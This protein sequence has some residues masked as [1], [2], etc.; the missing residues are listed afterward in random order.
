MPAVDFNID[1]SEV[2]VQYQPSADGAPTCFKY[3]DRPCA[4]GANG[5]QFAK[6]ADGTRD[7]TRVV[8]CGAACDKVRN[9]QAAK[10]DVI[11]GCTTIH[12]D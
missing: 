11:L 12:V 4:A 7:L 2:N 10:V 8:I 9:D 1:E 6:K 5:W 3:D